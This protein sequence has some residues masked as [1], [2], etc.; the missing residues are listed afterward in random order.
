MG[1]DYLLDSLLSRL[2]DERLA[3]LESAVQRR[4]GFGWGTA[5]VAAEVAAVQELAGPGVEVVID[6]G[7]NRG[8]WTRQALSAFPDAT[9][10]AFEPSQ[11]AFR[12]LSSSLGSQ[13]RVSLWNLALGAK[14]GTALLYAD[15]E[16]SELA[17]LT[18]RRLDHFGIDFGIE[19]RVVVTTLACWFAKS[20]ATHVDVL[21]LDA[22]G[23]ELEILGAATAVLDRVRV[24]QFEFGGCNIDTRSFLQDFWYLLTGAGFRLYRL[25]PAG[26]MPVARYRET[27]EVFSTTNYFAV[28]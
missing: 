18:R 7:A 10:H 17:S 14:E 4:R 26:L 27:D 12:Q 6:V 1:W 15:K 24:I 11:S 8:A 16:A 20:G 21:K 13:P 28:R 22:E 5:T 23:H 25:G 3:S 9:I 2:G 19:E